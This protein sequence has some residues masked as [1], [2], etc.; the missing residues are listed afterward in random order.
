MLLAL[1]LMAFAALCASAV[2]TRHGTPRSPSPRPAPSINQAY[3]GLHKAPAGA[4]RPALLLSRTIF[5]RG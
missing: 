2:L 4:A 1:V 5:P 3:V